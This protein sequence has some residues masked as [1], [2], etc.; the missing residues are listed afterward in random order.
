M[1]PPA[2]HAAVLEHDD[3][4]GVHDRGYALRH[5]DARHV[6]ELHVEGAAQRGVGAV[7]ERRERIV[8]QEQPRL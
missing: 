8:E 4:I 7:I 6:G 1:G 5:H 3:A 2:D